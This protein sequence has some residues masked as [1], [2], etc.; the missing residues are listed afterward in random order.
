MITD[1][2]INFF[3]SGFYFVFNL[4]PHVSASPE[5]FTNNAIPVITVLGQLVALPV[6]NTVIQIGLIWLAI[7]G[8]WQMVPLYGW[9]YG[10]VRGARG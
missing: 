1:L 6:I 5:W 9:L 8:G 7:L 4:L 2:F 3:A 10:K